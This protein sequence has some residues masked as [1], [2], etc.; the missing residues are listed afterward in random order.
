MAARTTTTGAAVL[1]RAAAAALISLAAG[2]GPL[3]PTPQ[4]A[5]ASTPG[6]S[7]V[8]T[9]SLHTCALESGKAYCWGRNDDGELGDGSTAGSIVPVAVDTSGALA[10]QT[11]TQISTAAGDTCALDSV[12]AA[13]CWG[14]DD[15]GQLGDAGISADHSTVPVAVDTSGVLAGKTLTHISTGDFDTCALD[16]AGAAFCWGYNAEGEL[17]DGSTTDS[18]VPVAVDTGGALAGKTLTQISAG[19]GVACVLDSASAAYC[20]GI[21]GGV[22]GDGST[23]DSSVPVAVDTTGALAGKTLTQISAGYFTVCALDSAGAAYCWGSNR[24]GGLGDGS[25]TDSSVPVAVDASGALAGKTLTQISAGA[26][27]ACALDRGGA[28]YCWGYNDLGSL[29]DGST[30]DSTVPVAVDT[31]GALA[32]QTLTQVAAGDYDVCAVDSGGAPYCWGENTGGELGDDSTASSDVPV[33]AG[34]QAPTDVTAVPGDAAATVSWTRPASLDGGTL[35]G[36]T[37][38]AAPGSA[39]CTTTGATTCTLTGLTDGVTYTVTVEANTT[40]G[41][42]GA[43]IPATVTPGHA[44]G[45]P[46]FTSPAA[47]TAAYGARLAFTI[48]AAGTPPPRITHTGPLPPG[49]RFAEHD[50]GTAAITGTPGRTAA[51]PY[52]LTLTATSADG[53]ASQA[54]TLTVTRPPA[55]A[56]TRPAV[57]ATTGRAFRLAIHVTGYPAPALAETGPLPAGVTFTRTSQDAVIAGTPAA[58]TAG[59]YPVTI[60]ATSTAGQAAAHVTIAITQRTP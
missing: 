42:S 44:T 5:L 49:L 16:S 51:G 6:A 12:G 21:G 30:S 2:L 59:R 11:L 9:G 39:A 29:G 38:T 52:H 57:A 45:R 46:A 25:T 48:T 32:G 54:F 26:D 4:A 3:A 1:R 13:Y 53:S 19:G 35:T 28:A 14:N 31:S 43:S 58:G 18:R 27:N 15:A 41:D 40:A 7:S 47:V 33:L 50:G 17:G 36:Y 55:L 37:A 22:L 20:W 8:S 10:G 23:T 60:T 56:T 34:P 24:D